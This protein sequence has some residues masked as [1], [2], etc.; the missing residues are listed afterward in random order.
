[1]PI[2]LVDDKSLP[3]PPFVG[4]HPPDD[5]ATRDSRKFVYGFPLP[6]EWFQYR[7]FH[8]LK[9]DGLDAEAIKEKQRLHGGSLILCFVRMC[10]KMEGWVYKCHPTSVETSTVSSC[11]FLAIGIPGRKPSAE[12]VKKLRLSLLPYGVCEIPRWYPQN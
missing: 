2:R 6:D 12:D 11:W 10:D 3:P 7:F 8:D 5:M 4:L 9:L 1:M